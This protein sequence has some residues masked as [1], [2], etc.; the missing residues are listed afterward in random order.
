MMPLEKKF[1]VRLI[2]CGVAVFLAYHLTEGTVLCTDEI[3]DIA[4]PEGKVISVLSATWG[5]ASSDICPLGT[6]ETFTQ[7]CVVDATIEA[8]AL[9]SGLRN[10]TVL[11]KAQIFGDPCTSSSEYLTLHLQ[12]VGLPGKPRDLHALSLDFSSALV[13]FNPPTDHNH[14]IEKYTVYYQNTQGNHPVQ[15]IDVITTNPS[16]PTATTLTSLEGA[17]NNYFRVWATATT[18]AGEGLQ[19]LYDTFKVKA[20]GCPNETVTSALGAVTIYNHQNPFGHQILTAIVP[21]NLEHADLHGL[22]IQF[23]HLGCRSCWVDVFHNTTSHLNCSILFMPSCPSGTWGFARFDMR[24]EDSECGFTETIVEESNEDIFSTNLIA[25][26]HYEAESLFGPINLPPSRFWYFIEVAFPLS[27]TDELSPLHISGGIA[28]INITSE[29]NVNIVDQSVV[30]TFDTNTNWPYYIV[31]GTLTDSMNNTYNLTLVLGGCGEN[32]EERNICPQT[33]ITPILPLPPCGD[34]GL[35]HLDLEVDCVGDG[36]ECTEEVSISAFFN[37]SENVCCNNVIISITEGMQASLATYRSISLDNTTGLPMTEEDKYSSTFAYQHLIYYEMSLQVPVGTNVSLVSFQITDLKNPSD[38]FEHFTL[39]YDE[40]VYRE[41]DTTEGGHPA[42]LVLKEFGQAHRPGS[43]I[44]QHTVNGDYFPNYPLGKAVTIQEYGVSC[45]VLL[46]GKAKRVAHVKPFSDDDDAFGEDGKESL[47]DSTV[48]TVVAMPECSSGMEVR[49]NHTRF[50]DVVE[51]GLNTRT[52]IAALTLGV[53]GCF[54]CAA[55]GLCC[56]RRKKKQEDKKKTAP[57]FH[58][59]AGEPDNKFVL[60]RDLI[61]IDTDGELNEKMDTVLFTLKQQLENL[62]ANLKAKEL[63]VKELQWSKADQSTEIA[64]LTSDLVTAN[65]QKKEKVAEL[66]HLRSQFDEKDA[67]RKKSFHIADKQNQELMTVM[68]NYSHK[69]EKA[70]AALSEK[71]TVTIGTQTEG[72]YISDIEKLEAKWKSE[73]EQEIAQLGRENLDLQQ[74]LAKEQARLRL[75]RGELDRLEQAK[76][77]LELD[78]EETSRKLFSAQVENESYAGKLHKALEEVQILEGQLSSAMLRK[79]TQLCQAL[80]TFHSVQDSNGLVTKTAEAKN[81]LSDVDNNSNEADEMQNLVEKDKDKK[82]VT[83]IGNVQSDADQCKE[84]VEAA[85]SST[86]RDEAERNLEAKGALQQEKTLEHEASE[87]SVYHEASQDIL[88]Q[89]EDQMEQETEAL[90]SE[91]AK[92]SEQVLALN[93]QLREEEFQ[94]NR[95]LEEKEAERNRK[96]ELEFWSDQER[97]E[98]VAIGAQLQAMQQQQAKLK[99]RVAFSEGLVEIYKERERKFESEV[100]AKQTSLILMQEEMEKLRQQVKEVDAKI[101]NKHLEEITRLKAQTEILKLRLHELEGEKIRIELDSHNRIK[102]LNE[103]LFESDATKRNMHDRIQELNGTIR[104]Y[105]R[106]R[107]YLEHEQDELDVK[108]IPSPV[109]KSDGMSL[110]LQK[111]DRF[112]VVCENHPFI[113]DKVFDQSATQSDVF[114]KVEDFVQSALDGYNVSIIGYGQTCAGKTYSMQGIGNGAM[115]GIIPRAIEQIGAYKADFESRGWTYKI[116]ASFLEI[117]N[118]QINDLLWPLSNNQLASKNWKKEILHDSDG[119]VYITNLTKIPVD[120]CDKEQMDMIMVLAARY[121]SCGVTD[122]NA[123]A[124]RSHAVF[125]LYLTATNEETGHQLKGKL[126][127][128]DLAGS[129]RLKRSKVQGGV[130][131]ES[132]S[133]N[134]SLSCLSDVCLAIARENAYV[135][136]RNSKLT[137]LLQP[138]LS[139]GGRTLM[140]ITLSPTQASFHESLSSLR[141]GRTA[142]L[143]NLRKLKKARKNPSLENTSRPSTT[144]QKKGTSRSRPSSSHKE[145]SR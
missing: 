118:E 107:P 55:A 28:L 8:Q 131:T 81:I 66:E 133:I 63:E 103:M 76:T 104:V 21:M 50:E 49:Q 56:W 39:F 67:M 121:R 38:M 105:V 99:H 138:S 35:Y 113:F 7:P 109:P 128:V 13:S 130:M 70:E 137:Y 87:G 64:K 16:S 75:R 96:Q 112:G 115:K 134:K 71:Q 120:P 123:E 97:N 142:G 51:L 32:F 94:K 30:I 126:N 88:R 54:F 3:S 26:V 10:C 144:L 57:I 102:E 106:V 6:N 129:E 84:N 24:I 101:S 11:P 27:L 41:Y 73:L 127:L 122:M 65:A 59:E 22:E 62:R 98:R 95:A 34:N 2:C 140:L 33:L 69:I 18:L 5:R 92:L 37:F 117:I 111:T 135:P 85:Q 53:A 23:D 74:E 90:K 83:L 20:A 45:G 9:C 46:D 125:T 78:F 47:F 77:R 72:P 136:Y 40:E 110:D 89:T 17:N 15:S 48:L 143:C 68:A 80:D 4:C 58:L 14:H 42:L 60:E 43:M 12:C 82:K 61:L 52:I 19:S 145:G 36:L 91:I 132:L 31:G 116:E 100:M 44:F 29:S 124:S 86:G 141:F 108:V 114:A 79:D 25:S 119:E 139:N 93:S 1:K